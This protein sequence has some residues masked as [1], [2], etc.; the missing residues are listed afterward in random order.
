MSASSRESSPGLVQRWDAD[1][2][3][4]RRRASVLWR[5]RSGLSASWLA[6]SA[7]A[8]GESRTGLWPRG[9]PPGPL[10]LPVRGHCRLIARPTDLKKHKHVRPCTACVHAYR[11]DDRVYASHHVRH[12]DAVPVRLHHGTWCPRLGSGYRGLLARTPVCP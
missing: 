7:P 10:P 8:E 4:I 1:A 6:G 5:A 2:A 3:R 12:A 9:R 11:P